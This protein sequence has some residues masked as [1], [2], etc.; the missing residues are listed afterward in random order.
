MFY[1]IPTY[2]IYYVLSLNHTNYSRS[3]LHAFKLLFCKLANVRQPFLLYNYVCACV[4]ACM[5]V[6]IIDQSQSG[7]Q[8][9]L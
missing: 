5:H 8:E 6:I 9:N 7:G 4:R 1:I 2:E 3:Y